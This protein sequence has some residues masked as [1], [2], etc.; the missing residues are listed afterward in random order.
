MCTGA[1]QPPPTN[2]HIWNTNTRAFAYTMALFLFCVSP[3]QSH[4]DETHASQS[5]HMRHISF[6]GSKL[7]IRDRSHS[8]PISFVFKSGSNPRWCVYVCWG[9]MVLPYEYKMF[10]SCMPGKSD[11][12]RLVKHFALYC[13]CPLADLRLS[14]WKSSR[15]HSIRNPHSPHSPH[16]PH[17]PHPVLHIRIWYKDVKDTHNMHAWAHV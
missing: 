7:R 9:L 10:G 8:S 14:V 13:K 11:V 16:F 4:R 5:E 1:H 3:I 17:S 6:R 2:K 15:L 12:A